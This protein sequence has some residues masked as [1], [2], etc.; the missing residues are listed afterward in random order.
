MTIA[1]APSETLAL[2]DFHTTHVH[3]VRLERFQFL[4]R[5]IGADHT[6]H[7]N[8]REVTRGRC[9]HVR[10]SSENLVGLAERGLNGVKRDGA[11]DED[12]HCGGIP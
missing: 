1:G 4:H 5:I 11:D 6:H 9:K 2:G 10:R 8:R 12:G 7:S 3:A